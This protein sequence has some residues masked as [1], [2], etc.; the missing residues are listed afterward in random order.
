MHEI[1]T[2]TQMT[3][4]DLFLHEFIPDFHNNS[5]FRFRVPEG[6]DKQ[7]RV[8]L[9]LKTFDEEETLVRLESIPPIELMGNFRKFLLAD[10]HAGK[11]SDF[12]QTLNAILLT[13]KRDS[14]KMS[15]FHSMKS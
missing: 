14:T 1:L 15:Y 7:G 3:A 9:V 12:T 2:K 13:L 8:E 11:F 10:N 6:R 5:L 4:L